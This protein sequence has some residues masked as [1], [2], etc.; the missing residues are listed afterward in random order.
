LLKR[1]VEMHTVGDVIKELEKFDKKLPV[2]LYVEVGEDMDDFH[3]VRLETKKNKSYCKGCHVLDY[4]KG[5]K[6]VVVI[7]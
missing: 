6:E 3:S 2:A 1:E 5:L 4:V 7:G